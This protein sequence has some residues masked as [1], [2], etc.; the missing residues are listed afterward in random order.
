MTL[1]GEHQRALAFP[2]RNPKGHQDVHV[3][4]WLHA[5]NEYRAA[6]AGTADRIKIRTAGPAAPA[7]PAALKRVRR[8]IL[9][10]IRTRYLE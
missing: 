2:A 8:D 10:M 3:V 1:N 5:D 4:S 6:W 7:A 9:D